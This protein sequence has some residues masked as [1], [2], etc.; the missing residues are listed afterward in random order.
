M[1]CPQCGKHYGEEES[2]CRLCA[3]PLQSPPSFVAPEHDSAP[4]R[5]TGIDQTL[6]SI[7]QDIKSIDQD[8]AR[9]AGFF[10]RVLAYGI[11]NLLLTLMTLVVSLG[12]YILLERSGTPISSDPAEFQDWL[13]LLFV[14][15]N[16]VLSCVYFIYFHAVTGQTVGK[17]ICGVQVVAS[18]GSRR[19]LGWGRSSVR[20]LGYFISSFFLYAGFLWVLVNRRKRGWHDYMAGSVVVYGPLKKTG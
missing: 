5:P 8:P 10:I 13:W 20:C 16:T 4:V 12:V 15:P 6:E 9:P 17:L 18:A 14:L 7:R 3:V 19:P 1:I 2:V 11:D